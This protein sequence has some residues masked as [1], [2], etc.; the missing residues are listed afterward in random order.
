MHYYIILISVPFHPSVC[1]FSCVAVRFVSR[2]PLCVCLS[3]FK[4]ALLNLAGTIVVIKSAT[5][6]LRWGTKMVVTLGQTAHYQAGSER[7][8]TS[9][10]PLFTLPPEF[11]S[12]SVTAHNT[13]IVIVVTPQ[14]HLLAVITWETITLCHR[15][16]LFFYRLFWQWRS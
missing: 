11:R 12:F 3:L 15:Y 13:D 8:N 10:S 2:S 6:F 7:H 4:F 16:F 14:H 9:D 1:L 5:F